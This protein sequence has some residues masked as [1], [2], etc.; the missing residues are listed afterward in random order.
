MKRIL[1]PILLASFCLILSACP[2]QTF[3]DFFGKGENCVSGTI[4]IAPFSID[5]QPIDTNFYFENQFF[6]P[7]FLIPG[8]TAIVEI[9]PSGYLIDL[10]KDFTIESTGEFTWQASFTITEGEFQ[11]LPFMLNGSDALFCLQ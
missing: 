7:V 6:N 2:D 10:E 1:K 9:L 5:G 11:S 8:L 3:N 4:S